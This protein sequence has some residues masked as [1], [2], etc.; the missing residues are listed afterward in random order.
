MIS[1]HGHVGRTG[2]CLTAPIETGL[3]LSRSLMPAVETA[4][5]IAKS[6]FGD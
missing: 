1:R 6:P 3:L 5:T 4:P 2:A